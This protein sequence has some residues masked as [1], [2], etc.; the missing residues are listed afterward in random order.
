MRTN[1]KFRGA[2]W[3]ALMSMLLGTGLSLLPV[4]S[5][6]AGWRGRAYYGGYAPARRPNYPIHSGH[7]GYRP[8]AGAAAAAAAGLAAGAV[9]GGALSQPRYYPYSPPSSVYI[10]PPRPQPYDPSVP[11]PNTPIYAGSYPPPPVVA[12]APVAP[13]Q[14]S[15]DWNAYCASKYRSFNP[16]TGMYKGYDGQFHYCR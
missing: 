8:Y 12:P 10:A 5:A 6:D 2:A 1:S 4:E 14:G 9:I 11:V 3:V 15:A 7:Y 13:V 16:A